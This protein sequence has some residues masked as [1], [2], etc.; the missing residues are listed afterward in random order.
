VSLSAN[1]PADRV[2]QLIALTQ[3]LQGRLDAETRL[4]EARRPQDAAAGSAETL[5]LANLYRRESAR[6]RAEPSLIAGAPLAR[7]RTLLDVTRSFEAALARHGRSVEAARIVTEGVVRAVAAQVA[8]KRTPAAG[9]GARGKA[10]PADASA[11]TLNRR[12]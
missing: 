12:A 8:A 11:I 2:E 5:E 7:R 4:F 10:R 3:R 1:D 6:V 9:Y